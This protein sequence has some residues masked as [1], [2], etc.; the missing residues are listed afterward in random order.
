MLRAIG[1]LSATL[2]SLL[3]AQVSS[4]VC[5]QAGALPV[6]Q[7]LQPQAGSKPV[8]KPDG[9]VVQLPLGGSGPAAVG[10]GRSCS[11]R[12][13]RR[14]RGGRSILGSPLRREPARP[15]IA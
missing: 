15:C 7:E 3:L 9:K 4:Q 8:V 11:R 5:D 10:A 2:F 13:A 6:D 1:V 12:R 14:R